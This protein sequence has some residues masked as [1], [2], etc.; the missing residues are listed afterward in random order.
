MSV[1]GCTSDS[2]INSRGP[3][4]QYFNASEKM[5]HCQVSKEIC[6]SIKLSAV[7][8]IIYY[9]ILMKVFLEWRG[10]SPVPN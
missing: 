3:I 4:H 7:S 6:M 5:N 9:F 10:Q 1:N 8:F 2:S